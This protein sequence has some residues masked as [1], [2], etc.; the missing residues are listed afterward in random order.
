[1]TYEQKLQEQTGG[2]RKNQNYTSNNSR[3]GAGD[4]ERTKITCATATA[5]N[6]GT[7]R[8]L[9]EPTWGPR[10]NQNY[11]SNSSRNRPG[12]PER[13]KITGAKAPGTDLG[14]KWEPKLHEQ[15]LEEPTWGPRKNHDY[16]RGK[17]PGTHLGITKEPKLDEQK[18]R[19]R[20]GGPRHKQNYTS[21]CS[22]HMSKSS[23]NWPG[24]QERTKTTR[25]KARGTNL[26]T[27]KEPK[28]HTRK[29]P[30]NAP[31]GQKRFGATS[32][33]PFLNKTV[34]FL[35]FWLFI[36]KAKFFWEAKR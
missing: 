26:G 30:R 8:E 9:Q 33:T 29:N 14:T 16:I 11:T 5:S 22:R 21:N 6:L 25:A 32:C 3:N 35:F 27:K 36:K 2:P 28:L 17:G 15:T 4:Q 20:T 31:G 23:R 12:D 19:E 13:I 24:D 7:K 18:L 1:M 10:E 34:D